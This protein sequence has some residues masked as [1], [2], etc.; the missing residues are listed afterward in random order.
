[1]SI[2]RVY[3]LTMLSETISEASNETDTRACLSAVFLTEPKDDR[4]ALKHIKGSRVDGTCTWIKGHEVYKSWLSSDAQLLWLSGSP[5]K[6]KTM[7]S[8]YIA[9]ELERSVKY[10]QNTVLLH[11]F[12]DN[13]DERRNTATAILRGL[14]FQLLQTRPHLFTHI[15]PSYR[16]QKER[17]FL[18]SSFQSL[19]RIFEAMLRDPVL[20]KTYCVLDGLDECEKGSLSMILDKFKE[21][22]GTNVQNPRA[23]RLNLIIASRDEPV[24]IPQL[25]LGFPRIKLDPDANTEVNQDIDWFIE[26]KVSELSTLR[27]YPSRLSEHIRSIFR[28]RAQGTF[29]WVGIVANNLR[30]YSKTEV[31]N[32]LNGFPPGLDEVY[33]RI[34]LEI[35]DRRR[36][37]VAKILGW[38]V[39]AVRPLT[40]A[41]LG[42]AIGT[43]DD[44]H[45]SQTE[46]AKDRVSWCS[47]FLTITG[48]E[49]H[50]I[51]QS[52]KDYLLRKDVDSNLELEVFRVKEEIANLEIARR[53][54]YYLQEGAL[55]DGP[56]DLEED[57]A[58]L[59]K[60]PLLSYA[61]DCWPTHAMSLAPSEDIFDLSDLFYEENSKVLHSWLETCPY[62]RGCVERPQ[63]P[64]TLL[65]IA[66][67]F[68]VLPLAEKILLKKHS[69]HKGKRLFSLEEKGGFG[70]TALYLAVE[71]G[72]E[73]VVRMLL[74]K[75]ADLESK[76]ECARDDGCTALYE[77]ATL[78]H[79]SVTRLLLH[80]G[81]D[82]EMKS[83]SGETALH[84]A[85]MS[86]HKLIVQLLLENGADIEAGT[87]QKMTPLHN[88]AWGGHDVVV[89]L[90]LENGADIEAKTYDKMTPLHYAADS[91]R[92]EKTVVQL[93]LKNGA[94]I[95]AK[96][97]NQTTALHRAAMD[98]SDAVVQ[99]LLDNGADIKAKTENKQ[100]TLHFA[101]AGRRGGP[102]GKVRL[103]LNHGADIEAK[104]CDNMTALH[105]AAGSKG[106]PNE[107][108]VRLLLE[109]G[110]R[111]EAKNHRNLTALH[112]AAHMGYD[113]VVQLLLEN[114]AD[115]EAKDCDNMT[116]LHYAAEPKW[117][118]Y[119]GVVRLLLEKGANAS[120][121]DSSGRTPHD[122]ASHNLLNDVEDYSGVKIEEQQAV[123]RLLSPDG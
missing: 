101:A 113:T 3:L 80:A 61:V 48:D 18:A 99:L 6:G 114:E 20:D 9:E 105:H 26:A 55:A 23:F 82:I 46:I 106:G 67:Y 43:S 14:I 122:I 25:L 41:E 36:E 7:I 119:E 47:N 60:F 21:L 58:Y 88:A 94:D 91:R 22:F 44:P 110:A 111:I 17:L 54:F 5:G 84:G 1:M 77:A 56:V 118:G 28:E 32:Y 57:K 62:S 81:A 74:D 52:A 71:G 59:I 108:V 15:L 75:G 90:L 27:E 65:H 100:T 50:L 72:H 102:E 123:I 64:F 96:D 70:R 45:L 12:C 38:T 120:V 2:A 29:L 35:E 31:V 85:T 68:G 109:N 103:L 98:Q 87:Y 42:V 83:G 117:E 78:G 49:V 51:H 63:H 33:A 121:T 34:L 79:E 10:S 89:Q 115:I 93:L 116:A 11:Y 97:N 19:W 104:D 95:E 4:E 40:L 73:E 39:M 24:A 107:N 112:A 37:I 86:G 69:Q 53:C 16:I 8:I 66:S 92:N 30:N 76:H 13:R